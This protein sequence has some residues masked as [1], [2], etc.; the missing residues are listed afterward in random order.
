[1]NAE[2]FITLSANL[3]EGLGVSA[4]TLGT[5]VF[6]F[7]AVVH[8]VQ[9]RP[10]DQIYENYRRQVGKG[11]LLGLELL[12]A[13]DIIRTVAVKPTLASVGVLA[14][15]VVIRTFLS[16]TLE[17]EMTGRWPWQK[18]QGGTR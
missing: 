5:L 6:T 15:I 4:I 1:M 8:L 17:M 16:F 10:K 14:A 11:I 7:I 18:F 2:T 9:N 12:I 3:L 13:A